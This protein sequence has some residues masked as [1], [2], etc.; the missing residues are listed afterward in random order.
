MGR[1]FLALKITIVGRYFG[2][3]KFTIVVHNFGPF[4]ITVT[5]P[6]C[7]TPPLYPTP[8]TPSSLAWDKLCDHK[9][10][11]PY[12]RPTSLGWMVQNY[13]QQA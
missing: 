3:S 8:Q 13:D 9:F 6:S 5:A 11:R 2:P 4:K 10:G 7:P 12:L 1:N